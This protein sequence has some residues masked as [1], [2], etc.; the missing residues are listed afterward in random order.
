MSGF[1]KP[2]CWQLFCRIQ[3]ER[4]TTSRFV[5]VPFGIVMR[6][7]IAGSSDVS[8]RKRGAPASGDRRHERD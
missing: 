2:F 5:I 4:A 3:H 6:A 7:E 8:H 1:S